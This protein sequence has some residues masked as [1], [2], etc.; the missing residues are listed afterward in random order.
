M[1]T[2]D[3]IRVILGDELFEKTVNGIR[4]GKRMTIGKSWEHDEKVFDD[5]CRNLGYTPFFE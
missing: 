2:L 4:S 1:K 5:L 3:E